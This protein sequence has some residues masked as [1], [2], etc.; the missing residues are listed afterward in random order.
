MTF[1]FDY[2]RSILPDI[3]RAMVVTI[4]AT[5]GA[6]LVAIVV[7]LLLAILR[8]SRFTVIRLL[9]GGFIEFVRSTPLL[10]QIFF[11]FYILPKYGVTIDALVAGIVAMGL[12]FSTF[13]AEVYRA[14]IEGVP[15]GQ[16]EA[17]RALNLP[18]SVVWLRVIIPQAIPPVIPALGNYLIE[19]FKA[20]PLLATITVIEMFGQAMSEAGSTYRYLEPFAIVGVLFFLLSYPCAIFIRRL[21]RVLARD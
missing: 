5:F 18:S 10:I 4:E 11:V 20:T 6:M 19:M 2:A 21:E 12:H 1:D 13:T 9:V 16:W 15:R 8:R 17:A 14:G 7:G 3:L